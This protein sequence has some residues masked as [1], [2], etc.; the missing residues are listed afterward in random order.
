MVNLHT[1][2]LYALTLVGKSI[3]Q[4]QL[5]F[6]CSLLTAKGLKVE[7]IRRLSSRNSLKN[8]PSNPLAS[9]EFIL[10]DSVQKIESLP[11]EIKDICNDFKLEFCIQPEDASMRNKRLI[12]FDLDSTLIKMEAIDELAD[13]AGKKNE[14][15]SITAQAMQGKLDFKQS[16]IRRVALLK[17]LDEQALLQVGNSLSLTEGAKKLICKLKKL[18]Y[19][20]ATLSGGLTYFGGIIQEQLGL[21]YMF[22][23]QLEISR[24]RLT[25]KING[26][27]IDG[28]AKARLLEEISIKEGICLNETIAVGD[29]ANDLPML[30]KAG[31]GIAFHA[32]PLVQEKAKCSVC[33]LGLDSILYFLGIKDKDINF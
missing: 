29:G 7:T 16:L 33:Y 13:L 21:D 25:G 30:E 17:G 23:N 8:I 20:T 3:N 18:G 1:A 27:I 15:S 26:E 4:E 10:K 14:V 6:I 11:A 19:K 22:A 31:M 28:P 5:R 9:L 24:G 12:A 32:K 2:K